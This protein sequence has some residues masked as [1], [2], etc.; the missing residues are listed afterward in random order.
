MIA[1]VIRN[2]LDQE[3]TTV[4]VK[5]C[6]NMAVI[7]MTTITEMELETVQ[8]VCPFLTKLYFFQ[9]TVEWRWITEE[10]K[11]NDQNDDVEFEVSYWHVNS[12]VNGFQIKNK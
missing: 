7:V 3:D 1:I 5:N 4:R 8:A 12:I 6:V 2:N 11:M 10:K 9:L